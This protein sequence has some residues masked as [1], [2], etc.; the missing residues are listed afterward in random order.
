MDTKESELKGKMETLIL[1]VGDGSELD[2]R[3]LV[4][5]ENNPLLVPKQT[6][7]QKEGR[8]YAT[9]DSYWTYELVD[10]GQLDQKLYVTSSN[11]IFKS[12]LTGLRKI[13]DSKTHLWT[14]KKDDNIDV[15]GMKYVRKPFSFVSVQQATLDHTRKNIADFWL[16]S[17]NIAI[18]AAVLNAKPDD[19]ESLTNALSN[20]DIIAFIYILEFCKKQLIALQEPSL[21]YRTPKVQKLGRVFYA[22]FVAEVRA[23]DGMKSGY[24]IFEELIII[25]TGDRLY[26]IRTVVPSKEATPRQEEAF[27]KVNEWLS[28][29]AILVQ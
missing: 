3:K 8:F 11:P 18:L 10:A 20:E 23:V 19:I 22:Q 25:S 29:F 2:V 21:V 17:G 9:S 12:V 5:A 26:T 6:I 16:S 7:F 1:R 15:A 13:P 28:Q 27:S 24:S 14:T 4:I